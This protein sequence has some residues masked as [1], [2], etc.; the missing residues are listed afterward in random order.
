MN[1]PW[2]KQSYVIKEPPY[3]I[4]RTSINKES[5][6]ENVWMELIHFQTFK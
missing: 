4:K 2:V 5:G 6:E 3:L 1:T